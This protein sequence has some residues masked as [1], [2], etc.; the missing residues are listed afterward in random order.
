MPPTRK[1]PAGVADLDRRFLRKRIGRHDRA[2]G[3]RRRRRAPSARR[4]RAMPCDHALAIERDADDA[5]RRDQHLRRRRRRPR[6]AAASAIASAVA[7][8]SGPVHA[9]AQ[10]LLITTT[11]ARPPDARSRAF[12]TRTGAACALLVVNTAAARRRRIADDQREVEAAG[13]LDAAG[14][15][16]GAEARRRRHAAVD[17][18]DGQAAG[19]GHAVIG[20]QPQPLDAGARR[21]DRAR[22]RRGQLEPQPGAGAQRQRHGVLAAVAELA[23]AD[24]VERDLLRAPRRAGRWRSPSRTKCDGSC[25]NAH[26]VT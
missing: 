25:V 16:G 12:D 9:L 10:P 11:R 4:G 7:S 6:C 13:L 18:R 22:R 3:R 17:G 15:A 2:R 24:A 5:G 21:R 14:D 23:A 26:S 19:D 20:K 1:V 8:P